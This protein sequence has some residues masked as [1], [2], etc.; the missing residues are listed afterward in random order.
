MFA[1]CMVMRPK[2]LKMKELTTTGS[3]VIYSPSTVFFHRKW[4][5]NI[6]SSTYY[7]LTYLNESIFSIFSSDDF[8]G[9]LIRLE[10]MAKI[11][12][13]LAPSAYIT[14]HYFTRSKPEG[15]SG[16]GHS[17]QTHS[18]I[19]TVFSPNMLAWMSHSRG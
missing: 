5:K 8:L 9:F 15:G 10:Q 18:N 2:Y 14:T 17:L 11:C 6:F 3:R 16:A 12:R 7:H 4:V 1:K 13:P 19:G